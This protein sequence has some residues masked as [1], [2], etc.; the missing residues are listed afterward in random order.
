[1]VPVVVIP[2]RSPQEAPLNPGAVVPFKD[3]IPIGSMYGIYAN[4]GGISMVNVTKYSIHGSY[5]E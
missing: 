2:W 5:E 1:M 3:Q 4:I